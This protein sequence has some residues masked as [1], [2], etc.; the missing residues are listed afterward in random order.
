MGRGKIKR[1]ELVFD[2]PQSIE[3]TVK[4]LKAVSGAIERF[5]FTFEVIK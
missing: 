1:I 3:V 2:E 5:D 4:T